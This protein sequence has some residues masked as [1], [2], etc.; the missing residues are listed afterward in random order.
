GGGA[1]TATSSKDALFTGSSCLDW[2]ASSFAEKGTTGNVGGN[3]N[4]WSS[5]SELP[6]A[7]TARLYCFER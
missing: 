2:T 6:C 7:Q 4:G 3:G 5:G 1:W